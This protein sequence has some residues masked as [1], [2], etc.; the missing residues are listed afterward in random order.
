MSIDTSSYQEILRSTDIHPSNQ[1]QMSLDCQLTNT[2]FS[3]PYLYTLIIG[4]G[5]NR[6]KV[7]RE[8]R[9]GTNA[10]LGYGNFSFN[11]AE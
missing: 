5:H 3:V 9:N 6:L 8:E 2:A 11:T 4:T 1:I 7:R 10:G